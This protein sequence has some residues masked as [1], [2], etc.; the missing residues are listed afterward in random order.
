MNAKQQKAQLAELCRKY[1]VGPGNDD[2]FHR[3]SDII[4]NLSLEWLKNNENRKI[5]ADI[6]LPDL[7]TIFSD[8]QIPIKGKCI[9]ETLAE[10]KE[11]ILDNSVQVSHPRYIGHM[12][13]ALPWFS[14]VTDALIAATNQNQVKIETALSSSFVERQN[15][16]WLHHLI[17]QNPPE[18]YKKNIQNASVALGNMT[19]GGTLGNL[20]AL[21]IAQEKKIPGTRQDGILRA[22]QKSGYSDAVIVGSQRIHYSIKKS[23]SVLGLGESSVRTV[24][25]DSNNQIN[26]A[27]LEETIEELKSKNIAI[28]AIIGVA[29]TTETGNIDPLDDL[30]KIAKKHNIW[31]H[32]DAAWGGALLLSH[33]RNR[34]KGIEK[35]DS[36][37]LDGHKLFYLPLAHGVCILKDQHSLNL[38]KHNANYILRK[39]SVDL[40]QTSLE[41]SR[42]FNSLKLWFALKVFGLEGY[43][44]L[45]QH[46][47]RLTETMKNMLDYDP[48]FER[49]ST[50]EICIITYRYTPQKIQEQLIRYKRTN[51]LEKLQQLNE[52]LNLLNVELQKRQREIGKSFVSRTTLESAGYTQNIVVL[53]TV[54]TNVLTTP[55][56]LQE[57]LEE[58]KQ[59]A[60]EILKESSFI[61]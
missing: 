8:F 30:A 54:L 27:I 28:I 35:A 58:Q 37:V 25:V 21:A 55:S 24:P 39:G 47:M 18:F 14:V 23:A 45:F 46:S 9:D 29:G 26:L 43:S 57:I 44:Q 15:L 2:E 4:T 53:R 34:L 38:L 12:T 41:G 19:S 31:F 17:Y 20:T 11:N 60:R 13:T 56:D 5:H 50:P 61:I 7:A 51:Q 32:V 1:F 52:K 36:V 22:M 48:D 33:Y 59:I 49:T 10:F 3:W 42:R 40:G 6:T 16:A